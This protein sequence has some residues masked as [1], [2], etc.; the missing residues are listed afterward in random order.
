MAQEWRRP[1]HQKQTSAQVRL[2]SA[3]PPKADI[4]TQ[5]W[6]VRFV[7]QADITAGAVSKR[8]LASD[9]EC[10][11]SFRLCADTAETFHFLGNAPGQEDG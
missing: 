5:P 10:E 1:Q 7:P 3:L 11:A 2:M 4:G 8:A 9:R 6:N